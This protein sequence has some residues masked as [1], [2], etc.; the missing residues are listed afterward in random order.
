MNGQLSEQPLAELIREISSKNFTGRL[1]LQHE[2]IKVAIYFIDGQ[3]LYVASNIKSLRLR[4]YLRKANLV[5]EQALER[6]P[7]NESDL[8]LAGT[9]CAEKLLQA[10]VAEQIQARQVSEMLRLALQWLDGTWE[11]DYRSRLNEEVNFK[12]DV[13]GLILEAARNIPPEFAASRFK[14][15]TEIFSLSESFPSHINLLPAEGFL[16]SRLDQPRS[17]NE[18]ITMSGARESEAVH[19]IYVLA[20]TGFIKRESWKSSFRDTQPATVPEAPKKKESAPQP[21]PA[22]VVEEIVDEAEELDRF[23]RRVSLANSHY[24]VLGIE[25]SGPPDDLKSIYYNLARRFHPDRYQ[26]VEESLK[27]KVESAFARITQAYDVL[28][29]ANLRSSYDRKLE[30][31]DKAQALARSAPTAEPP[32]PVEIPQT[33]DASREVK[34]E[35]PAT[36]PSIAEQ[37]EARF[38]EGFASFEL[39]Q[40]N[41]SIGLFAAAARAMPNEARYRSYHGRALAKQE[42]TRRKAE[43]ELQA[44]LKLAP[45]DVECRL[46]L[47]ELYRDLGFKLRAKNECERAIA[48]APNNQKARQLLKTIK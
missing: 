18:L 37:A 16:L 1:R 22:V 12:F 5:S 27:L 4:E 23:L 46:A 21:T 44:A 7:S 2:L 19:M 20:L 10:E 42:S 39:G 41:V 3:I 45:E 26:R 28:R 35:T 40:F 47:A 15:P 43:A 17:M 6:I 25:R 38:K 29:D 24:E 32:K 8:A 30:A 31:K 13:P 14:N 9:L 34:V 36:G 33:P 48:S 11:F